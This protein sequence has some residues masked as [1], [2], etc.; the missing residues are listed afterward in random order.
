MT[1]LKLQPSGSGTIVF[2]RTKHGAKKLARK[3]DALRMRVAELQGNLSQ[4]ARERSIGSFRDGEVDVLVATNV[5]ARGLDVPHVG[6]VVNYELPETAQWLTHRIGRTARN[7]ATGRAVTL[8]SSADAD[9][10]QKLQRGGAPRLRRLHAEPLLERGEWLYLAEAEG[11]G[12]GVP[13]APARCGRPPARR[14]AG[15]FRRRRA[16]PPPHRR[17]STV[18]RVALATGH[19]G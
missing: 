11:A 19:G 3:L 7:G 15:S 18:P 6:L 2:T 16:H 17:L 10:W 1:L 12:S 8:L 13:A 4:N 5:A 9:Q 14:P